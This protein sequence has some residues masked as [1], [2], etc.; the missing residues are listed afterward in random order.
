MQRDVERV[1][2]LYDLIGHG[3]VRVAGCWVPG[4]V[5]VH[6]DQCRCIE[7][8]CPF[9]HLSRVD[10]DMVDG[11]AALGLIRDQRVL[12]VEVEHS[13]LFCISVC[14]DRVTVIQQCVPV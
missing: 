11:A 1:C 14:H 4:G 6:E 2:R 12:G 3:D 9:H 5:V 8:Q 10:W 7:I 13:E